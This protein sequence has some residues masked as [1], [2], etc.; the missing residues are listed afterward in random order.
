[1]AMFVGVRTRELSATRAHG[2]AF[3]HAVAGSDSA[4]SSLRLL[5]EL[6]EHRGCVNHISFSSSGASL[7]LQSWCNQSRRNLVKLRTML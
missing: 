1:V 5:A 6:K 2:L 3:Q 7:L 4:F